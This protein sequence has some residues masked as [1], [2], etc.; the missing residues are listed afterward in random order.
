MN[1]S[2]GQP[3]RRCNY[4]GY[5]GCGGQPTKGAVNIV[6]TVGVTCGQPTKGAVNI[7]DIAGVGGCQRKRCK[8]SGDSRSDRWVDCKWVQNF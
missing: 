3:L 4:K 7:V 2:G 6:D 5:G 8:Y 1:V